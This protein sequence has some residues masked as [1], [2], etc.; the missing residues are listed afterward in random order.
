MN[1]TTRVM[2][3]VFVKVVVCI[4][5]LF[6][7]LDLIAFAVLFGLL[8]V[9]SEVARPVAISSSVI[10]LCGGLGFLIAAVA[11]LFVR[12]DAP[13]DA[14]DVERKLTRTDRLAGM[15]IGSL[16]GILVGLVAFFAIWIGQGSI[17]F[18]LIGFHSILLLFAL[19]SY[20]WPN[21]I[22]EISLDVVDFGRQL[23]DGIL[24]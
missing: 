21:V 2:T 8:G 6:F 13:S 3:S 5:A 24:G 17:D 1:R 23:V 11:A 22:P 4:A 14:P 20:A 7:A 9:F 15:V 10:F 19:G 16:G 12:I 18:A